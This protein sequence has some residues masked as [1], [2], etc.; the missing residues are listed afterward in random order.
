MTNSLQESLCQLLQVTV[1]NLLRIL[2]RGDLESAVAVSPD[3]RLVEV[4]CRVQ[5]G[6]YMAGVEA[7]GN[8]LLPLL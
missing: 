6:S 2:D 5:G 4:T 3:H 8:T 1:V 7:I